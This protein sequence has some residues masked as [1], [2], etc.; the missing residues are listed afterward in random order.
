MKITVVKEFT[1][2][3]AH[4]LP[5]HKGKCQTMHGH[6]YRLQIG[7][8]GG[9]DEDGLV[10]DFSDLKRL[11]NALIVNQLDHKNLNEV[12]L[13]DFPCESPTAENMVKWIVEQLEEEING[14]NG[15]VLAFVRLYETPTSYAEWRE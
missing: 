10:I 13:K 15:L 11:V 7:V 9:I 2:D 14:H 3:S 12:E 4:Y 6:T 8:R 5:W 1:F